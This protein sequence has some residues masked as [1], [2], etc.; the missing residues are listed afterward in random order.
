MAVRFHALLSNA[1]QIV[2][3][4][5]LLTKKG[6]P[7]PKGYIPVYVGDE[8]DKKKYVVPLSYLSHPAF[9]DL[10]LHAEEEFGFSHPMGGLTHTLPCTQEA[11]F[12]ITSALHC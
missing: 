8:A 1:K 7:V 10:L 11:F 4:Q 12:N 2:K 3:Q 6:K 5:P 9:Q